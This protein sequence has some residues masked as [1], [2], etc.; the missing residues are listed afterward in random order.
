MREDL[1]IPEHR[2]RIVP[3]RVI[4]N[5]VFHPL[6][7]VFFKMALRRHD[8]LDSIKATDAVYKYDLKLKLWFRLYD[9]LDKPYTWWGTIYKIDF[10]TMDLSGEEW[11]DHNKNGYPYW[12]FYEWQEDPITGDAWRL[13]DND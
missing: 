5:N 4:G 6:S 10:G 13:I 3:L 11:D 8:Y 7:M 9:I 1:F 2:T 12:L